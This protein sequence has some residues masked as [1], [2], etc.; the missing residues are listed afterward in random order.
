MRL[1]GARVALLTTSDATRQSITAL[2]ADELT[3]VGG[4][5]CIDELIKAGRPDV[6]IVSRDMLCAGALV[7]RRLR[8]RW[9]TCTLIVI[10]AA[11]EREAAQLLDIGAD[12]VMVAD[13]ELLAPRL[14]A[15][16]RRAR[17]INRDLRTTIGDIT[18]DRESRRIWC[19]GQEIHLTRTEEALLDC[20]FWYAPDPASIAQ[21][22]AFAW[23][24][25]ES[26]ER[27]NL[28]H[29]YVGS[30]RKKL[31]E[32][33]RVVIQTHRGVGYA[34]AEQPAASVRC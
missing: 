7:L 17:T 26:G 32:S 1:P 30:L 25:S 23:G 22:T 9:L 33:R 31:R 8:Q 19:A 14:R 29:V 3:T 12:N 13:D 27:R 6:V 20:L 15:A 4:Y 2:L 16:A 28:V 34:F 18:Y 10:G 5:E 21:L 24:R 11:N